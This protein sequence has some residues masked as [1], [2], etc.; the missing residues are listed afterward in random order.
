MCYGVHRV[1]QEMTINDTISYFP[2]QAEILLN[3]KIQDIEV[4]QVELNDVFNQFFPPH[5][6]EDD[7]IFITLRKG[8]CFLETSE[9]CDDESLYDPEAGYTKELA[10]S[11]IDNQIVTF[12]NTAKNYLR[13]RHFDVNESSFI[14]VEAM[15]GPLIDSLNSISDELKKYTDESTDKAIAT[16]FTVMTLVIVSFGTVTYTGISV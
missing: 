5:S 15:V 3:N 9:M 13:E 16:L 14:L 1:M 11:G 2:H 6:S 7:P 4:M 8:R 12:L 10:M